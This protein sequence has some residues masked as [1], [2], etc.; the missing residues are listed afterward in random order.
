[1]ADFDPVSYMMGQKAGPGGGSST[2]SGLTDVDISN[3]TDGQTLVYNATS[4]KWENGAASGG[5]AG[6][7][8]TVSVF[9][10]GTASEYAQLDKT[11]G[12]IYTALISG[13][14]V[15]FMQ[16]IDNSEDDV[17]EL[18][19]IMGELIT[20]EYGSDGTQEYFNFNLG[21][22]GNNSFYEGEYACIGRN[23]NPVTNF[24][25]PV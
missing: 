24:A 7:A 14:S 15:S 6:L 13:K 4:G 9:N 5:D 1:M 2:L 17:T 11:A 10:E 3:P 22:C 21:R 18:N 19:Y 12:E 23:D 8:V 16:L 25:P 20:I